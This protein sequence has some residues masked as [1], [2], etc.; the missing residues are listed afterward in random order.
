MGDPADDLI[1]SVL[2]D[3]RLVEVIGRGG[4]GAVFRAEDSEGM[5]WAVK[6]LHGRGSPED[7]RRLGRELQ[8]AERVS[9]P[10]IVR[11]V[12]SG[13][14]GGLHFLVMECVQGVSL[15][16]AI[17]RAGHLPVRDAVHISVEVLRALQTAHARGIV[18]RDV[19]PSNILLTRKPGDLSGLTVKLAD[20][21]AALIE[22]KPD[23]DEDHEGRIVGSMHYM[24]PEQW[25][26]PG[27]ADVRSDLYSLGCTFFE[28]LC[29]RKPFEGDNLERLLYQHT[30]AA[31]PDPLQSRDMPVPLAELLGKLLAADPN[32]RPANVPAL[33]EALEGMLEDR[34]D[35]TIDPDIY[36]SRASGVTASPSED[37]SRSEEGSFVLSRPDTAMRVEEPVNLDAQFLERGH[38]LG[39]YELRGRIW[40][41]YGS[42]LYEAQD[43]VLDIEVALNILT[44]RALTNPEIVNRF[45][46][47]AQAQA[48]VNHPNVQKV[49]ALGQAVPGDPATLYSVL[50]PLHGQTLQN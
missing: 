25:A 9:H 35:T 15:R 13:K 26:N 41:D 20:F 33:I 40:E 50:D 28:A 16:E 17:A 6:V 34:R 38:R 39:N 29:G 37:R 7:V 32:Q 23:E 49:F 24:A 47:A 3:Y 21:G 1:G 42:A 11:I 30:R 46:Q 36:V 48:R 8:V 44:P 14:A 5:A 31:R 2:G 27:A 45:R 22:G 10:N 18:H 4:A 43:V 19:K 12:T